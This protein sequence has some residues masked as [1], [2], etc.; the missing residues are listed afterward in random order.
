MSQL[1]FG[2]NVGVTVKP[3]LNEYDYESAILK[4]NS[5]QSNAVTIKMI[6]KERL[7][8]QGRNLVEMVQF[9][10]H[11]GLKAEDIDALNVIHVSG[12]KGKGSTCAFTESILRRLGYKTGFYR[13]LH[14]CI[15]FEDHLF[16]SVVVPVVLLWLVKPQ[17]SEEN[18][19]KLEKPVKALLLSDNDLRC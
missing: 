17:L 18:E 14:V 6:R 12:T 5:L 11:C 7:A 9:M 3:M 15:A 16:S 1:A 2:T 13:L 8:N 19:R 4:L 10:N